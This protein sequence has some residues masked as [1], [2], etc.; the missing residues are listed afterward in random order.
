V[1][2]DDDGPAAVAVARLLELTLEARQALVD[3]LPA[4]RDQIDEKGEVVDP[5]VPFGEQ[6]V[7]QPF[8]SANRLIR[9]ATN[10]G[11][12]AAEG[13]GLGLD[14]VANRVLDASRER[15][16]EV[17]GELGERFDLRASTLEG[18]IDVG[19]LDAILGRVFKAFARACDRGFVH[20]PER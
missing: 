1:H 9:E 10:F 13:A 5:R 7:L 14:A 17:G 15:A 11:E 20:P 3:A 19:C 16:L 2:A 18:G 8:E 6:V 12:L 4:G